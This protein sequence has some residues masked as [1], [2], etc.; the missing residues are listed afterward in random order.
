MNGFTKHQLEI[1]NK[2]PVHR[3]KLCDK[4]EE[5]RPPEGGIDMSSTRWYC[6]TCWAHRVTSRNLNAKTKTA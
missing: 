2:Q 6:C 4:C 5:Q 1:G 3:F